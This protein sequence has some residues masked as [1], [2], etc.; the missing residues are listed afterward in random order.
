MVTTY[1]PKTPYFTP[2]RI[3]KASKDL[4]NTCYEDRKLAFEHYTTLMEQFEQDSEKVSALQEATKTLNSLIKST[5]KI[6]KILDSLSKS[7]N[8][9]TSD[10]VSDVDSKIL[11]SFLENIN[12]Q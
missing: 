8:S 11:S 6:V 4:I 10:D 12:D 2:E 5:E 7:A 9:T 1:H 3:Q